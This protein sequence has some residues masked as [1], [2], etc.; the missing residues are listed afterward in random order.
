[1]LYNIETSEYIKALDL[2]KAQIEKHERL[3]SRVDSVIQKSFDIWVDLR[4]EDSTIP[5]LQIEL[6]QVVFK[7]K[8]TFE[9]TRV[10]TE[11]LE[12]DGCEIEF[13]P[14]D[15]ERLLEKYRDKC[16]PDVIGPNRKPILLHPIFKKYNLKKGD[17]IG[18]NLPNASGID[19]VFIRYAKRPAIVLD[20]EVYDRLPLEKNTKLLVRYGPEGKK[21]FLSPSKD[22]SN[23]SQLKEKKSPEN[24]PSQE[25]GVNG[26][27]TDYVRRH[28]GEGMIGS[29]FEVSNRDYQNAFAPEHGR[30]ARKTKGKYLTSSTQKHVIRKN[31]KRRPVTKGIKRLPHRK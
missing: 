18:L 20:N 21:L 10:T 24:P 7:R 15:S 14:F 26:I 19:T 12:R 23:P 4:I 22:K 27:E 25:I 6:F 9:A 29:P 31:T 30:K 11:R 3:Y 16:P 17:K 28:E 2:K 1:L 8:D 13:E 5:E